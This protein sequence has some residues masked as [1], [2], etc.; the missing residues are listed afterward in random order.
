MATFRGMDGSATYNALPIGNLRSWEISEAQGQIDVTVK[1]DTHQ[2]VVGGLITGTAR[3]VTLLDYVTGQKDIADRISATTPNSTPA[4]LVV[5]TAT[6]KTH[7]VTALATGYTK[8]SPDGDNPVTAEYT[9]VT[10]SK[11]TIAWA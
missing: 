1:G 6:G 9:F 5:T 10:S 11:V 3:L 8:T 7:T 2:Q 4:T